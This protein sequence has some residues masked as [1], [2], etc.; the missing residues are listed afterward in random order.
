MAF[1]PKRPSPQFPEAA[2]GKAQGWKCHFSFSHL[3]TFSLRNAKNMVDITVLTL[4][5]QVSVAL[6]A[7]PRT[8]ENTPDSVWWMFPAWPYQLHRVLPKNLQF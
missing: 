2:E 4:E 1:L 8:Y 3:K 5:Q 6:L 7:G